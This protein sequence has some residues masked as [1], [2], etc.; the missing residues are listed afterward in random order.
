M[1]CFIEKRL[2]R[3]GWALLVAAAVNTL[4]NVLLIPPFGVTGAALAT[5]LGY[6]AIPLFI[7]IVAQ[8]TRPFPFEWGRVVTVFVVYLVLAGAGIMLSDRSDLMTL[9]LRALLLFSYLPLLWALRIFDSHELQLATHILRQPQLVLRRITGSAMN[10]S[11]LVSLILVTYNSRALLEPFF[12]AL[13]ETRYAPYEVIVVDNASTDETVAYLTTQQPQ[14]RVLAHPANLGFG[15]ACNQGRPDRA[16][17]SPD[18]PQ[19]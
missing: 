15:R 16:R 5:L 8:R 4:L 11:P 2:G 12:A 17:R 3:L 6:L 18:L 9:S 14:V 13:G 1:G 7:A 10:T 19:P